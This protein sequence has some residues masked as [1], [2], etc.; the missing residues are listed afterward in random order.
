MINFF[1][2]VASIVLCVTFIFCSSSCARDD[3][4]TGSN[5]SSIRPLQP[6]ET[7]SF[8]FDT[9]E[10]RDW[11]ELF[12]KHTYF[13]TYHMEL[14]YNN[15]VGSEWEKG[16]RYNGEYVSSSS[17]IVVDDS[18]AEIELE[19]FATE[20]DEWNDDGTT[21]VTFDALEV[22]QTQ[23]KW[24]TVVVIEDEGRYKGNTAE[25]Y[26]EITIERIA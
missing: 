12:S 16:V 9:V 10:T 13:V 22:G 1:K 11:S 14:E 21:H 2:I 7:P 3:S 20:L 24:A 4:G 17:R 6:L 8:D 26:F 19:V 23:T 18:L 15:S 25:W 5:G